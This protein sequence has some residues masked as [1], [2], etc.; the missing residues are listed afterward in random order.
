MTK[1]IALRLIKLAE[2]EIKEWNKF[3]EILK[4]YLDSKKK[5]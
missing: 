4:A 5:L 1:K 2:T 3:I